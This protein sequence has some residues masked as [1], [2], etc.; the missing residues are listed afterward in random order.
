MDLETGKI[1]VGVAV[2]AVFCVL[3]VG[4]YSLYKGGDFARSWSNKLMRLRV[5]LQFAAIIIIMAV[6]YF[7]GT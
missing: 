3:C 7:T 6:L 1:L 4:I 5:V 2:F